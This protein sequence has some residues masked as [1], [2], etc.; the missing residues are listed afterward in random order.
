M[1][2]DSKALIPHVSLH[3]T[4]NKGLTGSTTLK[5]TVFYITVGFLTMPFWH[6]APLSPLVSNTSLLHSILFILFSITYIHI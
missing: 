2:I 1:R 4:E 3:H 6:T 5:P